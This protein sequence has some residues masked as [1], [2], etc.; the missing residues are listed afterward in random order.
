M[1]RASGMWELWLAPRWLVFVAWRNVMRRWLTR[2]RHIWIEDGGGARGDGRTQQQQTPAA[3]VAE[4]DAQNCRFRRSRAG[5]RG[6][7]SPERFAQQPG[8]SRRNNA[9]MEDACVMVRLA[10]RLRLP[11]FTLQPN[12]RPDASRGIIQRA[13]RIGAAARS[14]GDQ[15]G[16]SLQPLSNV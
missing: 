13:R 16:A 15:R 10:Q 14:A 6:S 4:H 5:E 3:G 12:L 8:C 11:L 9:G 7:A 2:A 1:S